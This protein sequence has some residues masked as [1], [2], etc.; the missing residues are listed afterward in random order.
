[1]ISVLGLIL[2][3]KLSLTSALIKQA[4]DEKIRFLA[5]FILAVDC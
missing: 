2:A 5:C 4:Y 3:R 1:M